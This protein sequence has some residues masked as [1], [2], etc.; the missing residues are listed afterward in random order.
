MKQFCIFDM[1]GTL[2]DSM[3]Y[4]RQLE[5]FFLS[6]KGIHGDIDPILELAKPLSLI[7]STALFIKH[8][9][10]QGTPE[11]L[12]A[13]M[14]SVMDAHY[15][16]DI[17]LKPGAKEY[18]KTLKSQGCSMC[19]ASATPKPLIHTCLSHLG[20]IDMFDFILSCDEVGSGKNRPD[21]FLE[22]VHRM[23]ST[24]TETAIFEDS[25][26]AVQTGK[27]AGFYVVG[28]QDSYNKPYWDV[29]ANTADEIIFD[30]QVAF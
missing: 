10:L 6:Q 19:I 13:E 4:W 1:D 11:S 15:R 12:A 27:Q 24:P 9:N 7:E 29:L 8:F 17:L 26:Q 25:L 14:Q 16:N 3:G 21:V 20:V 18:L 5:R 22:A 28:I 23:G 2:V 30:W